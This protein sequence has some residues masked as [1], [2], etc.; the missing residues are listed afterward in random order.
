MGNYLTKSWTRPRVHEQYTNHCNRCGYAF[1]SP[2]YHQ[3]MCPICLKY[4]QKHYFSKDDT[5]QD[6]EKSE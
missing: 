1:L 6:K 5:K 2:H 4:E 3:M